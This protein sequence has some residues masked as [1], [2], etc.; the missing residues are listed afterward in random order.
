ML[1]NLQLENWAKYKL[2]QALLSPLWISVKFLKNF[3]P[4]IC[5]LLNSDIYRVEKGPFTYMAQISKG[6]R[7]L[8]TMVLF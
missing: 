3:I 1:K 4:N 7:D 8:D 5:C 2:L 6:G